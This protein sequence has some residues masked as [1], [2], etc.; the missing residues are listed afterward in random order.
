MGKFDSKNFGEFIGVVKK[1]AKAYNEIEKIQKDKNFEYVPIGD[2]KTGVIGEAFIFEYLRRQGKT[3]LE[4]GNPAQKGWDIRYSSEQV[5]NEVVH[6]Q[7]KT[8][9]AF[10]KKQAIGPIHSGYSELYLV[11]LNKALIPDNMW[12]PKGFS[13]AK[14]IMLQARKKVTG[15]RMPKNAND[16]GSGFTDIEDIFEKFKQLFPELDFPRKSRQR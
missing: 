13:L 14:N 4:F 6:V 8:V 9:S 15:T 3:D 16:T 2:Q 12:M 5:P 1:Y 10:A 11:S 7:I